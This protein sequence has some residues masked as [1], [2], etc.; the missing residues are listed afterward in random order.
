MLSRP[1]CD[2]TCG[3]RANACSFQV[4]W[5]INPH[6]RIGAVRTRHALRQ[7]RD[8]VRTLVAAGA[9]VELVPFVHGAFDSVFAKD[10]AVLVE[11][12]AR[13]EALLAQPRY[14]ERMREQRAR[15]LALESLGVRVRAESSAPLEGGDVVVLP[16]ATAALLGYGYRSSKA[17]A[18]E[19]EQ[20]LDRP[21]TCLELRDPRLYH[22]D[23]AMSVLDD[24]TALVC[25]EAFTDAAL[26]RLAAHPDIGSIIT[27]PVSEAL[28][29]AV[30][31]VQVGKN[32]VSG[33]DAPA[34]FRS[35]EARGYRVHRVTL[36]EF[37]HAGGSAACLVSKIHRQD[38]EDAYE[39]PPQSHAA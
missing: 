37:H 18:G 3:Q 7:H 23:M 11:R 1:R 4:A 33:A 25:R 6:M 15:A 35:L 19:L 28:A 27:V 34:T 5:S 12:D 39:A 13:S 26:K 16:G 10:N 14:A 9:T 21:V 24:G 29:F 22:L 17:A 38:A 36:D 32:I 20:F 31:L 2:R 30:N 8:F